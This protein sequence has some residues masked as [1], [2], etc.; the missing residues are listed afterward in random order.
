MILVISYYNPSKDEPDVRFFPAST[1][2]YQVVCLAKHLAEIPDGMKV[3]IFY[4]ATTAPYPS[5]IYPND[6][7]F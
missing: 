7:S 1:D 6:G 4:I 3:M 5:K 2:E